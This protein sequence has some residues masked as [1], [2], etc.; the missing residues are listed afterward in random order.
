[1]KVL[2]T[3][4]CEQSSEF[5][6]LLKNYNLEPT[7]FPVLKIEAPH[8]WDELDEKII[9]IDE[10]DALI[11]TSANG[12]RFFFERFKKNFSKEKLLLK[13]FCAVGGKTT[14]ALEKEGF[15]VAF[16]PEYFTAKGLVDMIFK[17]AKPFKKALFLHGNLS[18]KEVEIE[19]LKSGIAVDS[20]EVYRTIPFQ[21][22]A[23]IV[24]KTGEMLLKGEISVVTF[25]SPSS[26]EN[27]LTIVSKEF[28]KDVALAAVGTTTE[29]ALFKNGLKADIVPKEG[30]FTA[31]KLAEEIAEYL[32]NKN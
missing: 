6:E 25:F 27:F 14:S 15:D 4:S 8:S 13:T 3:R 24:V 11:F 31:E 12:V 29:S 1:M 30:K 18:E 20:V 16:T 19:L 21:P 9:K 17:R 22:E 5:A 2:I 10:Y 32:Q 23:E 26:V 28:L 7:F